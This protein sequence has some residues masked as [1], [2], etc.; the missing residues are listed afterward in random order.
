MRTRRGFTPAVDFMPNRISPSV[1]GLA[2]VA[3]L[4][5]GV[6]PH[7]APPSSSMMPMDTAGSNPILAG[8]PPQT[9]GGN[10]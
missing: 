10:C 5:P 1:A 9:G 3:A 6:A 8:E 4:S 7:Q 2:L